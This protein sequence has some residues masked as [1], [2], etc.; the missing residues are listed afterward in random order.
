[1]KQIKHIEAAEARARDLGLSP[2]ALYA[3]AAVPR[4]TVWR[5]RTGKVDPRM[6]AFDDVM[7][8]INAVLERLSAEQGRVA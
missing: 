4:A 3:R 5:W 6:G 2:T 8:R 7:G 1:M